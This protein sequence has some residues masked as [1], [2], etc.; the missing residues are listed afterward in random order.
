MGGCS[1]LVSRTAYPDRTASA[2][3]A[4]RVSNT[5]C[6]TL[7]VP[8]SL[9]RH[10]YQRRMPSRRN[11]H[12]SIGPLPN[13]GLPVLLIMRPV[14]RLPQALGPWRG[15]GVGMLF[16]AGGLVVRLPCGANLASTRT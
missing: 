1:G 4:S 8:C 5:S 14:Q 12:C 2:K 9:V 11:S 10:Q 7:W 15:S 6:D 13:C 16:P 3:H